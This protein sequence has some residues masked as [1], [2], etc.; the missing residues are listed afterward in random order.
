MGL[1]IASLATPLPLSMT[2]LD[3]MW[4]WQVSAILRRCIVRR[5]ITQATAV[6][7]VARIAAPGHLI[8]YEIRGDKLVT[9]SQIEGRTSQ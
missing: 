6:A 4:Q 1:T 5:W 2:G 8:G 9:Y 7:G 3:Q